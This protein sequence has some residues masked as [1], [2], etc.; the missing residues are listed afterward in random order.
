M[1]VL[2]STT[3]QDT[4]EEVGLTY[5][6]AI[7][8]RDKD[9][10]ASATTTIQRSVPGIFSS[11]YFYKDTRTPSSVKYLSEFYY[12]TYP[13]VPDVF[14][15]G[16]TWR[17]MVLY[18]NRE[19][20][21]EIEL[22]AADNWQ[23]EQLDA[24]LGV[25]YAQCAGGNGTRYGVVLP[26]I[27]ARCGLGGG[28]ENHALKWESL[29]DLHLLFE[30]ASTTN[31]VTFTDQDFITVGVYS[32][33]QSGGGDQKFKLAAL[34]RTTYTFQ[35]STP[36]HQSP[37]QPENLDFKL[38]SSNSLLRIV[39]DASRDSDTIDDDLVYEINY[40]TSTLS[41]SGWQAV[42][43]A[44]LDP[45]EASEI[46]GRPFTKIS[47]E[48]NNTY[49]I[50][51]RAK[52]DFGNISTA[53]STVFFVPDI[54]PPYGMTNIGWGYLNSTSTLEVSF[55]ANPYPFMTAGNASAILFFLN[56]YPP[57]NY[58]FS[59]NVERWEIGGSHTVLK[60]K[61][62][63]CSNANDE[64][65]GGLLMH[66]DSSCPNGGNGLKKNSVRN[67]LASGQ[68]AFTSTISGVLASGGSISHEF[69][70]NDYITIGFYELQGNTFQEVS[71]YNKKIYFLSKEDSEH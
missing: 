55:D 66:N 22:N 5:T 29:E 12:N 38:N 23:S 26:D 48:P 1:N 69:S 46:N 16:E 39:W 27:E 43:S 37:S 17:I 34:D 70:E 41:E 61:Y 47:V 18:L 44:S 7:V 21:D 71:T 19:A 56:Q 33:Y 10:L 65:L 31:D 50:A 53:T 67:D 52:D 32:L 13:F 49:H 11:G 42:P 14:Q 54:T 64:L 4:L 63:T 57:A 30:L 2:A 68:T 8:A 58:S 45:G 62:S 35:N 6:L 15:Q 25:A 3:Y 9:G 60:L 51:L 40:A 20:P 28:V 59:N 36:P 24:A